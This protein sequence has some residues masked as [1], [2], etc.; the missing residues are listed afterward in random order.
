MKFEVSKLKKAMEICLPAIKKNPV[1]AITENFY[2]EN[3]NG[4][5]HVVATDLE[6]L[7]SCSYQSE[8]NENFATLLNPVVLKAFAGKQTV[9]ITQEERIALLTFD[10]GAIL[11]LAT[12]DVNDFPA[13]T[14]ESTKD[15]IN[16]QYN[17][18]FDG[19]LFAAMNGLIKLATTDEMRPAMTGV[20]IL[21]K[22][23]H[24]QFVAS[25][26]HVL[27]VVKFP[28]KSKKEFSFVVTK[29]FVK[30]LSHFKKV[31]SIHFHK[32]KAHVNL[33][34]VY[35]DID[36]RI[37]SRVINQAYPDFSAV[38]PKDQ[39]KKFAVNRIEF[40]KRLKEILPFTNR[41]TNQIHVDVAGQVI[42]TEDLDFHTSYE[43]KVD[44][45]RNE[46]MQH[47]KSAFNCKMLIML[48]ES[49]NDEFVT[50]GYSTVTK[51]FT[52]EG[53]NEL[54]LIMPVVIY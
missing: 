16:F 29:G 23:K 54:L 12:D 19:D 25:D 8:S 2:I 51:P 33:K 42:T 5:M 36:V 9:D 15:D 3:N 21:S 10:D 35:S 39:P 52:I 17:K 32:E 38:I 20:N 31:E 30:I 53:K 11:K 28:F 43:C 40:L 50:I 26:G 49:T 45:E 1:L 18:E 22:E 48:L 47:E 14:P 4:F 46:N 6:N 7:I 41:T 37:R 34:F 24:L 13:I 27:K 44:F